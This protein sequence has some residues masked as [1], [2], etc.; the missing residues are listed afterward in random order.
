M[1]KEHNNYHL[2]DARSLL[3]EAKFAGTDSRREALK[4]AVEAI[5]HVLK[6]EE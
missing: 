5:S 4:E 6:E 3:K 1:S 2:E